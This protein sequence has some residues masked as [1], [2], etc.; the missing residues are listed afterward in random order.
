MFFC[1]QP[2]QNNSIPIEDQ[3]WNRI[4]AANLLGYKSAVELSMTTKMAQT[5]DTVKQFLDTLVVKV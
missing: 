1:R 2:Y 4:R 3:R 5:A